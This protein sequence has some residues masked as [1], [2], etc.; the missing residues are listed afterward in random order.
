MLATG[1]RLV[2]LLLT[3]LLLSSLGH[4]AGT[5]PDSSNDLPHLEAARQVDVNFAP[6]EVSL[7]DVS[8]AG[9]V[10]VTSAVPFIAG[11][12]GSTRWRARS[13][14]DGLPDILLTGR[15]AT[16]NPGVWAAPNT[17]FASLPSPA[18]LAA[19]PFGPRVGFAGQTAP[20]PAWDDSTP[21]VGL[22]LHQSALGWD[23]LS[24]PS[25]GILLGTSVDLGTFWQAQIV[26]DAVPIPAHW[27][28]KVTFL[29][30][31][32]QSADRAVIGA[33]LLTMAAATAA[34]GAPTGSDSTSGS[35]SA[36][37]SGPG[38]P[39]AD[40][41]TGVT[42]CLAISHTASRTGAAQCAASGHTRLPSAELGPIT[43]E[44]AGAGDG[45]APGDLAPCGVVHS[46]VPL[47]HL[48]GLL[49]AGL[50]ALQ[51]ALAAAP[52]GAGTSTPPRAL[53]FAIGL[54]G[55]TTSTMHMYSVSQV[56]VSLATSPPVSGH[57]HQATT[58]RADGATLPDDAQRIAHARVPTGWP[59]PGAPLAGHSGLQTMAILPDLAHGLNAA[60]TTVAYL[61]HQVSQATGQT[62]GGPH[63][64]LYHTGLDTTV[65]VSL[66]PEGL[67][68]PLTQGP[69]NPACCSALGFAPTSIDSQGRVRTITVAL[70]LGHECTGSLD[71]VPPDT[72]PQHVHLSRVL[73][74]PDGA[75]VL[76]G[77]ETLPLGSTVFASLPVAP[78]A[79]TPPPAG[80]QRLRVHMAGIDL[81]ADGER[82][83]AILLSLE[84]TR[85]AALFRVLHHR[86]EATAGTGPGTGADDAQQWV[87]L[88]PKRLPLH[89]EAA[90]PVPIPLD[91]AW[92]VLSGTPRALLDVDLENDG[93]PELCLLSLRE[94]SAGS[95]AGVTLE[96]WSDMRARNPEF[97]C[98][99]DAFQAAVWPPVRRVL[100]S[101][102]QTSPVNVPGHP[103]RL[104]GLDSYNRGLAQHLGFRA[105]ICAPGHQVAGTPGTGASFAQDWGVYRRCTHEGWSVHL[106]PQEQ[107]QF[108]FPRG[109]CQR[110]TCPAFTDEFGTQFPASPAS[111][112]V[113]LLTRSSQMGTLSPAG[114]LV[115]PDDEG[116]AE[117]ACS[118][119]PS[120]QSS[121]H[122]LCHTSGLWSVGTKI[123]CQTGATCSASVAF[124]GATSTPWPVGWG[125]SLWD[126]TRIKGT[127]PA[128]RPGLTETSADG[129]PVSEVTCPVGFAPT[130]QQP[131]CETSG[132]RLAAGGPTC[133]PILCESPQSQEY[134]AMWPAAAPAMSL[135]P[136]AD[137]DSWVVT[138]R[139]MDGYS[140]P[141]EVAGAPVT[142]GR[143]VLVVPARRCRLDGL[144]AVVD[145]PEAGMR[146]K[147]DCPAMP[148]G[149]HLAGEQAA[150]PAAGSSEPPSDGNL[151]PPA[152]PRAHPATTLPAVCPAGFTQSPSHAP[153]YQCSSSL[154][155]WQANFDSCLFDTDLGHEGFHFLVRNA[156]S[157]RLTVE[158]SYSPASSSSHSTSG[159]GV[160]SMPEADGQALVATPGLAS[161][162]PSHCSQF[163]LRFSRG[164]FGMDPVPGN[165]GLTRG[166]VIT[167][168]GLEH[169]HA[170][171]L[172]LWCG[173]TS[174]TNNPQ[175]GDR[176]PTLAAQLI[177]RTSLPPCG[178]ISATP[179][180]G[181]DAWVPGPDGGL[182]TIESTSVNL[183][184]KAPAVS[185]N[186]PAGSLV[187]E[188]LYREVGPAAPTPVPPSDSGSGGPG[189][190]DGGHAGWATLPF[191]LT[192]THHRL[193]GLRLKSQFE[194]R[195]F[196]GVF[197]PPG[198]PL[199]AAT[200][201]RVTSVFSPEGSSTSGGSSSVSSS[202]SAS[203]S[204]RGG[205]SSGGSASSSGS[206]A[207]V[208]LA[209]GNA[210]PWNPQHQVQQQQQ[211]Q[212]QQQHHQQQQQHLLLALGGSLQA[213]AASDSSP[214]DSASGSSL[215]PPNSDA[216]IP[217]GYILW[218]NAGAEQSISTRGCP[219]SGAY[220][221]G[222]GGHSCGRCHETCFSCVGPGPDQCLTCARPGDAYNPST[223]RCSPTASEGVQQ[224]G[225]LFSWVA[226][227]MLVFFAILG[228]VLYLVARH[229]DPLAFNTELVTACLMVADLVV[230]SI[231]AAEK[232]TLD[233]ASAAGRLTVMTI[234]SVAIVLLSL[235]V[236]SLLTWHVFTIL[237]RPEGGRGSLGRGTLGRN[238][239]VTSVT[240]APVTDSWT[241]RFPRTAVALGVLGAVH[242][243]SLLLSRSR[244]FALPSLNAPLG[245]RGEDR[246][247]FLGLLNMVFEDIPQLAIELFR[248]GSRQTGGSNSGSALPNL[249]SVLAATL[250]LLLI[251]LQI[252]RRVVLFHVRQANHRESIKALSLEE[253]LARGEVP[254]VI[255][256]GTG[257]TG[258][259]GG[260]AAG[261]LPP[262]DGEQSFELETFRRGG[263]FID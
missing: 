135:S 55:Q 96:H 175:H 136:G 36:S 115:I 160:S 138:G 34:A 251:L 37:G 210:L 167:L 225:S 25:V 204:S 141:P 116:V 110:S 142:E 179:P 240:I 57:F 130:G 1:P 76:M 125:M 117:G 174:P 227:G 229:W 108:P 113:R 23:S 193:E 15:L 149:L 209:Q 72:T 122:R 248:I 132:W 205:T 4:A 237:R 107:A 253:R 64:A 250:S 173:P 49:P 259:E 41:S 30:A 189:A 171:M 195:V 153:F 235:V 5:S 126:S 213:T 33:K 87:P 78:A 221:I 255:S 6:G 40:H 88:A 263:D 74:T 50:V 133:S 11:S 98:P 215:T 218:E 161:A 79:G 2:F 46:L 183:S 185:G 194:V 246:V 81:N 254:D 131:T 3:G 224:A 19:D 261:G 228:L 62:R 199:L 7:A 70:A 159:V 137:P 182:S 219:T 102:A 44:H 143:P 216:R 244:V 47:V 245:P 123:T 208:N 68:H 187:Y 106:G 203:S 226:L 65:R 180:S 147:K 16:G 95:L 53:A 86:G 56:E 58:L 13:P 84:D 45:S 156:D 114:A 262:V 85:Q 222:S 127:F 169:F 154:S 9:L 90:Q 232:V 252:L 103:A 63:L 165:E 247:R 22:P 236:N 29:D 101:T 241:R 220:P 163:K 206:I 82:D 61:Y 148:Q 51:P 91:G 211:Q 258:P 144:S 243:E 10:D 120:S 121:R 178:F 80:L 71:A 146:C 214:S 67:R 42:I 257:R 256:P 134:G 188:L 184:W 212:H 166:S 73:L 202:S 162:F 170:F 28:P 197:V 83:L 238:K 104:L 249:T 128:P 17:Y 18:N 192:E 100:F 94:G 109:V 234:V 66:V 152:L 99:A 168:R 31:G 105:G 260:L 140:L 196:S 12:G 198:H 60:T 145:A 129:S 39:A 181:P 201:G 150:P 69:L 223:G 24:Q 75:A 239:Q 157:S 233:L 8:T 158:W 27:L 54:N 26:Q 172:Q 191:Y 43:A 139:C 93:W 59:G 38:L 176:Y 124:P 89:A 155:V 164:G 48:A 35:A 20:V 217:I 200:G 118:L 190:G 52:G 77:L 231:S 97:T 242:V 119:T 186:V 111:L 230:D 207:S 21:G 112:T 177:A 32:R 14:G 151:P 92:P